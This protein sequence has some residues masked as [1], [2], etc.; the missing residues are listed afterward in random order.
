MDMRVT[1]HQILERGE[2]GSASTAAPGNAPDLPDIGNWSHASS[3]EARDSRSLPFSQ[4]AVPRY[5]EPAGTAESAIAVD[6]LH[7]VMTSFV[8]ALAVTDR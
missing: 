6:Q 1:I 4:P 7:S 2:V 3:P 5:P 8:L